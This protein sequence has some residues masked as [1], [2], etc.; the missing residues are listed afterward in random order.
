M[1]YQ[2]ESLKE[3]ILKT[4][5]FFD[6]FDRPLTL[7]ELNRYLLYL[8]PD[9][10]RIEN[11]VKNSPLLHS[12][13]GYF[14]FRDRFVSFYSRKKREIISEKLWKKVRRFGFLFRMVPFVKMIAVCNS[15]AYNNADEKSD[16]DLFVV[17]SRGRLFIARSFL[18][19][20]LSIFGIRLHGEKITGRFCLSFLVSEDAMNLENLQEKPYD[21]YLA[22]WCATLRPILG[23]ETYAEFLNCNVWTKKFFPR[24]IQPHEDAFLE[25]KSFLKSFFEKIFG[26]ALGDRLEKKLAEWQLKRATAKWEKLRC[27]AGIVIRENL[28]KFHQNDRRAEV[29]RKWEDLIGNF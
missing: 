15:L 25:K 13:D 3:A 5:S 11:Y 18:M 10:E 16:I 29:R 23:K 24:E 8:P 26:G 6:I 1:P 9:S 7:K 22:Y 28:L 14:F 19:F 12:H 21:I 20:F 17:T 4:F 2:A 27:P